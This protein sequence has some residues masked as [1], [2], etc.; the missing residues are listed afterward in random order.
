VTEWKSETTER[1]LMLGSCS[2][3]IKVKRKVAL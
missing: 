1:K 3:R 2:L